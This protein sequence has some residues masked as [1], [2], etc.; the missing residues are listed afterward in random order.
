MTIRSP[1]RPVTFGP[2]GP[3]LGSPTLG[4]MTSLV[5]GRRRSTRPVA[6]AVGTFALAGVIALVLLATGAASRSRKAATSLAISNARRDAEVVARAAVEPE[7]T[8]A[9]VAGDPAAVARLDAVVRGRV[10]DADLVRVKMWTGDGRIVYSD[11]S[12]LIGG[13]YTLAKDDLAALSTGVGA[14][15]VSDLSRP[16]N[17]FERPFNKLLEVYQPVRT[18]GGQPLLFEAY[19][20]YDTV[21]SSGRRIWGEFVPL[22]LGSLIG[23]EALQIPLA[24]SMARRLRAGQEYQERLLR[25]AVESSDAER[26]RIARDLHDGVVQDLAGVSYALAAV[27]GHVDDE[28]SPVLA[29]AAG[30]TR[31]SIRALRSLLVEIYPPSLRDAGLAAALSDLVAPLAGNGI[32]ASIDLAADLRFPTDVEALLYRSAQEAVRNVV[33][34]A[35]AHHVSI[36]LER[37]DH[38]AV[39]EVRDDGVGFDPA[40]AAQRPGQG[41]VG[42]QL[43]ADLVGDAG[44]KFAVSSPAT[45]G[46]AVRVEVPLS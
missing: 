22:M 3:G 34:H 5:P 8:D 9:L 38:C 36:T 11:E 21:A 31:R 43:L 7:V 40:V 18:P 4:L 17:R 46:T 29:D 12:R 32:D 13:Q 33:A 15:D 28:G 39:L 44:G 1:R 41:H 6:R 45:G 25:R 24:W 26:R 10:L 27:G 35:Q 30:A 2:G 37:P 16:E 20:R 23:L 14:A 19:Y 42:L